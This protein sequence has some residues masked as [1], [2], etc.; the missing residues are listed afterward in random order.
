Q[1]P[2]KIEGFPLVRK[3]GLTSVINFLRAGFLK[4]LN[5]VTT[6]HL[7]TSPSSLSPCHAIFTL[8]LSPNNMPADELHQVC[9]S[10]PLNLVQAPVMVFCTYCTLPVVVGT[11]SSR[12]SLAG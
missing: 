7:I 3:Y 1:T 9:A 10:H 2:Y 5:A 12:A 4:S 6:S 11:L 8:S